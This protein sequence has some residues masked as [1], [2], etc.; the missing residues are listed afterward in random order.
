MFGTK[1]IHSV[2]ALHASISWVPHWVNK[3]TTLLQMSSLL[4]YS[5][6]MLWRKNYA[7]CFSPVNHLDNLKRIN[8]EL[9]KQIAEAQ[10]G[11][12]N[13]NALSTA[14]LS[15]G[16]PTKPIAPHRAKLRPRLCSTII[17]IKT[18]LSYNPRTKENEAHLWK[19]RILVLLTRQF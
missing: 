6:T 11:H 17:R 7:S 19:T 1:S 9:P 4:T 14:D 12:S 8:H 2:P 18:C 16:N 15:E 5:C 10:L 13:P 3:Q